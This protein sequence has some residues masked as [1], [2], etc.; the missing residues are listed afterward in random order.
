MEISSDLL[1]TYTAI[2][3]MAVAPIFIGSYWSLDQKVMESMTSE[4]AR[5][6]PFIGSGVLFGLYL[7]FKL[8]S[9]EYINLLLTG[10]FLAFGILAVCTTLR[11]LFGAILTR[12]FGASILTKKYSFR[13]PNWLTSLFGSDSAAD[14]QQQQQQQQSSVIGIDIGDVISFIAAVLVGVWYVTTKH[15]I[16]NNLLG[17][18]F[19]VQGVSLLSLG[20]YKVGCTL[21]SGLFV[22]DIFWVFGTDVMVTVAKSFE[23]PVKLL[24]PRNLLQVYFGAQ[25]ADAAFQFSMLGLGDI[26]IPGIFVALLLRFDIARQREEKGAQQKRSFNIYF[27]TCLI[28]YVIGLVSTIVVMHVFQA[29]QPALLY[30]VPAC[31][32]SSFGLA[33]IRGEVNKLLD[34]TDNSNHNSATA[35]KEQKV[36]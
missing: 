5:R 30:L 1:L 26:V 20:S 16:S 21:L 34:Y 35:V 27:W 32:L 15:W 14:K 9:K 19:S 11:P 8:F 23:A 25:S 36:N 4:D 10:Y 12:L 17:L 28:A 7:L 6:F 2:V 24:F 33:I 13:L 18:S 22:Y 29:A 3:A 31:M